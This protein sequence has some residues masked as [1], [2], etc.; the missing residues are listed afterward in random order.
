MSLYSWHWKAGLL[1]A[2]VL[3]VVIRYVLVRYAGRK[4][5]L[6]LD[7]AAIPI[8][9]VALLSFTGHGRPWQRHFLNNH[10]V[11]HYYFGAKYSD[12]LGYDRLYHCTLLALDEI[13]P[14]LHKNVKKVRSLITYVHVKKSWFLDR[15]HYCMERWSPERWEE[16]EADL[17]AFAKGRPLSWASLLRDKGYNP[18]PIWNMVGRRVASVISPQPWWEFNLLGVLDLLLLAAAFGLAFRAFGWWAPAIGL[19]FLAGSYALTLTHIRGAMLR[20]DWLAC[21][22]AAA[23]ALRLERHRLAG[24]L[25]AYASLVRVFPVLFLFGPAVLAFRSVLTTRRL[26]VRYRRLFGAFLAS[27]ILLGGLSVLDDGGLWR[28]R[29]FASK[30]ALHSGDISTTRLGLEYLMSYRGETSWDDVR[31]EDGRKGFRPHYVKLKQK[32]NTQNRSLRLGIA[33]VV[34]VALGLLLRGR[35]DVEAMALGFPA[36]YVLVS[37]TFYYYCLLVP[38]VLVLADRSSRDRALLAILVALGLVEAS[39]H[40]IHR[41]ERFEILEH[42]YY[43]AELAGVVLLTLAAL[44]LARFT[45]STAASAPEPAASP[46]AEQTA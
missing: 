37:T 17:Q 13:N 45:R 40:L 2:L 32:I 35:D 5:R 33:L 43:T 11:Y 34:L 26:A 24:A 30:M 14:D 15:P 8:V 18:S 46:V 10:D 3:L 44:A 41:W 38:V 16:F 36:I 9:A 29:A 1:V 6:G 7:L 28:W 27:C 20:L 21:L 31:G 23:A 25:L 39:F 22:I 19:I 42:F 4:A 12:E